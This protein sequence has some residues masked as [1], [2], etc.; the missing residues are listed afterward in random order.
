MFFR[1]LRAK[2]TP[3]AAITHKP[4]HTETTMKAVLELSPLEETWPFCLRITYTQN[5]NK[6]QKIT[7]ALKL[8]TDRPANSISSLF[9]LEY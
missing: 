8:Q 1:L 9:V 7:F 5:I 2:S 4:A 3:T 6:E